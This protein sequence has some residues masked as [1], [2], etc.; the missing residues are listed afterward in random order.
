MCQF[1]TPLFVIYSYISLIALSFVLAFS[2]LGK[3]FRHPL[4][5]NAFCF[6][7]LLGLWTVGDLVQWTTHDPKINYLF[8]RL[9]YLIDFFFLFF[10]YFSYAL[11]G[12]KITRRQSILF[13]LPFVPI[14]IAVVGNIGLGSVDQ[15]CDYESGW[16]I[17]FGLILDVIYAIWASMILVNKYRQPSTHYLVILQ[18]RLLIFAIMFFALW[19]MAYEI[20]DFWSIANEWGI[21]IS[22]YFILGNLSFVLLLIYNIVEYEMFSF[23]SLPRHWFAFAVLSCIFLGMFVLANTLTV[24][25]FVGVFYLGAIWLF[26]ENSVRGWLK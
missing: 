7:L 5:R 24:H 13:A 26:W 20:V 17:W 6:M 10:I 25:L 19:N 23:E 16:F 2:I 22:P 4:N 11:A 9:S 14:I 15:N 18:I 21:D 1:E 12:R 3:N 8:F